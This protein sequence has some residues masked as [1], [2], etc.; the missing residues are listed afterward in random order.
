MD[1]QRA[2]E[3]NDTGMGGLSRARLRKREAKDRYG[4]RQLTSRAI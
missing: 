1:G 2:G 3:E 4:E